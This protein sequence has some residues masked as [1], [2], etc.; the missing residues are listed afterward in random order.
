MK[1]LN[2]QPSQNHLNW[3]VRLGCLEKEHLQDTCPQMMISLQ[4]YHIMR[5]KNITH[6]LQQIQVLHPRDLDVFFKDERCFGET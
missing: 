4:I 1:T 5:L 6:H 3:K 2:G